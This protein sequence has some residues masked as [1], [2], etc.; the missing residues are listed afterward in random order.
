M[1]EVHRRPL[2]ED[3][4]WYPAQMPGTLTI[5]MLMSSC[6]PVTFDL[7]SCL[8]DLMGGRQ[9]TLRDRYP[10]ALPSDA[11][12]WILEDK[13]FKFLIPQEE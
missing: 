11:N 10:L 9:E 1:S 2:I 13:Y 8:S 3:S 7:K 6:E 5:V 4:V 12:K